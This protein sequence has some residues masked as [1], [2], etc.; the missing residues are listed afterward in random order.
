MSTPENPSGAQGDVSHQISTPHDALSRVTPMSTRLPRRSSSS[1]SNRLGPAIHSPQQTEY[2]NYKTK[3]SIEAPHG[4]DHTPSPSDRTRSLEDLKKSYSKPSATSS[5][6][7]VVSR[8]PSNV[9]RPGTARKTLSPPSL[10]ADVKDQT[11]KSSD[12][13]LVVQ[14]A[15]DS[16]PAVDSIEDLS[17]QS[18]IIQEDQHLSNTISISNSDIELIAVQQDSELVQSP[19]SKIVPTSEPL[20]VFSNY[21]VDSDGIQSFQASN[22]AVISH[23]SIEQE[24]VLLEGAHLPNEALPKVDQDAIHTPQ[25][26]DTSDS[27]KFAFGSIEISSIDRP[28]NL[29]HDG[30]KAVLDIPRVVAD[31]LSRNYVSVQTNL[32]SYN[33]AI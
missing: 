29:L 12:D 11:D 7:K 1:L 19:P 26:S 16:T 5:G 18:S 30:D 3:S 28:E 6:S 13:T 15:G 31:I 20:V 23:P 22:G 33:A 10:T 2:A 25:K 4:T 21:P 9:S 27:A 17:T 14:V 8:I 32:S 24:S